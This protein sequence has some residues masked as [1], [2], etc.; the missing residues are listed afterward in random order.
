MLQNIKQVQLQEKYRNPYKYRERAIQW[1]LPNFTEGDIAL[2]LT[3]RELDAQF[4][5]NYNPDYIIC[6]N[7][8]QLVY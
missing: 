2:T 8:S 5:V 1:V 6:F 4:K 3:Y 7:E